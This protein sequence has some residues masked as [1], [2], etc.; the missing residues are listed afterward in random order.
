M[1]SRY[2][3]G[4][5][6]AYGGALVQRH[7]ALPQDLANKEGKGLLVRPTF[8][9]LTLI[10]KQH[11]GLVQ[12]C[13]HIRASQHAR[14]LPGRRAG[15]VWA[16]E[17]MMDAQHGHIGQAVRLPFSAGFQVLVFMQVRQE[18]LDK[19]TPYQS[20]ILGQTTNQ[21]SFVL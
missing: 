4:Q 7:V 3:R 8:L 1:L 14:L 17:A 16:G 6:V 20:H 2:E 10:M 21:N 19:E 18:D 9:M 11:I 5:R 15:L 13:S 12:L